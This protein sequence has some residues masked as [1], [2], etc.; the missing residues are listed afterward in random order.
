[1]RWS[2]SRGFEMRKWLGVPVHSF[3]IIGHLFWFNQIYLSFI[4]GMSSSVLHGDEQFY[5]NLGIFP[6]RNCSKISSTVALSTRSVITFAIGSS[7]LFVIHILTQW[8]KNPQPLLSAEFNTACANH[9]TWDEVTLSKAELIHRAKEETK[10]IAKSQT[11][12]QLL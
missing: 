7:I 10:R 8:T 3:T 11:S 6:R 1:M 2:D 12:S 4:Y 5:L 9:I